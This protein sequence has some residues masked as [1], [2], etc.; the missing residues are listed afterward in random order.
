MRVIVELVAQWEAM[1]VVDR[2]VELE[3]EDALGA[4]QRGRARGIPID[5][6]ASAELECASAVEVDEEQPGTRFATML[7]SVLNM[8]LPE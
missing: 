4:R 6:R 3:I 1:G 7:P 8:L 5:R 2:F